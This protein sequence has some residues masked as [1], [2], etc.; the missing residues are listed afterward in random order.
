MEWSV[1]RLIVVS[2]TLTRL[3]APTAASAG[4]AAGG[5]ARAE[6]LISAN[7]LDEARQVL[8][9]VLR[10]DPNSATAQYVLG[11]LLEKRQD[12]HGAETAYRAA[13]TRDARLAKAHDRLGFVLG[14]QGSTADAIEEFQR[15][16]ALDPRTGRRAISPRRH[17]LVDQADRC[18]ARRRSSAPSRCVRRMPRPATTSAW[19]SVSR[20]IWP[21]RSSVCRRDRPLDPQLAAAHLQLGVALQEFGDIDG[22][23]AELERA[24]AH[25]SITSRRRQQPGPGA[26]AEGRRARARSR[27]CDRSSSGIPSSAARG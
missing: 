7:Q 27:R 5:L 13:L 9:D 12:L 26:D 8:D 3:L 14:L 15:A 20:E 17:A 24:V 6:R 21:A 18:G 19:S 16:V 1:R 10:Q 2:V 22:A 25:R 11:T 23:I 4:Q